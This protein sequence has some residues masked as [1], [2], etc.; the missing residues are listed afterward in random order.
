MRRTWIVRTAVMV[1]MAFG[2]TLSA[3]TSSASSAPSSRKGSAVGIPAAKAAIAKLMKRP[4]SIGITTPIKKPIPKNITVDFLVCPIT[5]CTIL[6]PVD[7]AAVSAL[8]WKAR[9]INDGLTPQ[10]LDDAM[11]LAVSQHPAGIFVGGFPR[12]EMNAQIAAAKAAGVP[13]IDSFVADSPGNGITAVVVGTPMTLIG[14][15]H[16]ADWVLAQKGKAANTLLLTSTTFPDVVVRQDGFTRQYHKLCPS[17]K[18]TVLNL[19]ATTFGTT[20][21]ASI[22][23]ELRRDPS[24]NYIAAME[25]DAMIGLPQAM[26]SAGLQTPI[27]SG[28]VD[29]TGI[30]YLRDHTQLK[31]LIE[32]GSALAVWESVDALAR[33]LVGQ[34]VR[35]DEGNMPGWVI[36]PSEAVNFHRPYIQVASSEAQFKK[37]WG[38]G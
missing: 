34:S 13:V 25:P 11:S 14:G 16:I 24:I 19:P 31:A 23:A 27:V 38:L 6:E 17:C 32:H 20:A 3:C 12:S 8:G 35:P 29:P 4:T 7:K 15:A 9:F 26:T 18:I 28:Y 2:L 22:M 1:A 30:S 21:P 36:T 10:A 5:D 37:L 33:H